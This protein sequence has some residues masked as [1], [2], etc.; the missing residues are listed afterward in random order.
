[1]ITPR[2]VNKE[3]YHKSD[4]KGLRSMKKLLSLDEAIYKV[5]CDANIRDC[6][7]EAIKL[8]KR[9]NM[10]NTK[11]CF[12]H[13]AIRVDIRDDSDLEIAYRNFILIHYGCVNRSNIASGSCAIQLSKDQLEEAIKKLMPITAGTSEDIQKWI[14]IGGPLP[15]G[16]S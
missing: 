10:A 16:L 15:E 13:S 5:P 1:M 2:F 8:A 12:H 6:I 11:V 4:E 7:K 14:R 9:R 3:T